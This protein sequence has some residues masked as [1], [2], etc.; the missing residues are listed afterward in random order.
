MF[1]VWN[2]VPATTNI[3]Y[4][5]GW[6]KQSVFVT[7]NSSTV[8]HEFISTTG[9]FLQLNVDPLPQLDH[10]KEVNDKLIEKIMFHIPFKIIMFISRHHQQYVK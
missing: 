10:F 3:S 8:K 9:P 6:Q 2:N 5:S 1:S 7:N 4:P